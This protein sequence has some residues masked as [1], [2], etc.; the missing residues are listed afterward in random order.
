MNCIHSFYGNYCPCTVD[1]ISAQSCVISPN[2]TSLTIRGGLVRN[3]EFHCQCIDDNGMMINGM[4]FRGNSST[5]LSTGDSTSTAPYQI[6]SITRNILFINSPF[7]SSFAATYYCS[8]NNVRTNADGD[9]IVL[10]TGSEYCLG[11]SFHMMNS[12]V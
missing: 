4:W 3:I 8:P 11:S 5:A 7:T 10:S 12:A 2:I 9:N 6:N 1:H